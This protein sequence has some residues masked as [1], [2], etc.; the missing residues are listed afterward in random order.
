MSSDEEWERSMTG[1]TSTVRGR[2]LIDREIRKRAF[3]ALVVQDWF[4]I[5]Y[6]STYSTSSRPPSAAPLADSL[7]AI[8]PSQ[9]KTPYPM[10]AHDS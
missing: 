10:N 3:F 5:A 2:S 4:S 7:S 9:I 1:Q 8:Q 6:R